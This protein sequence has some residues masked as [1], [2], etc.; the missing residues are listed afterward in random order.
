MIP[1]FLIVTEEKVSVGMLEME[2][3]DQKAVKLT[4]CQSY[5]TWK[6]IN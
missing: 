2:F 3:L 5:P 1:Y 6:L 4:N